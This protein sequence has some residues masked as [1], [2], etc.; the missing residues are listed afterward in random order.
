MRAAVLEVSE[1]IVMRRGC[2]VRNRAEGRSGP[3][4]CVRDLRHRRTI[5]GKG[6]S[7]PRT[8]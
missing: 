5:S 1:K 6:S 8:R 7:S 3:L 4:A 2:R